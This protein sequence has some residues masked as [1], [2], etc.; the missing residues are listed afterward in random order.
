M[1]RSLI[2][3]LIVAIS[4]AMLVAPAVAD[5]GDS[6]ADLVYTPVTPCRI[7]DTRAVAGGRLIPGAQRDFLVSGTQSFDTQGGTTGGCGIPDNATAAMLNFVAVTPSGPGDLRAWPYGQPVPLASIV[8]YA[9]VAGLNLANGAVVA[10]CNSAT[11]TCTFDV[12]VQADASAT[13]LVVDVIGFLQTTA[14][15]RGFI[16]TGNTFL[17]VNAGNASGTDNTA[18]GSR[19]LGSNTGSNNTAVGAAALAANMT[20]ALN[21]AI[22]VSALETNTTGNFNTATGFSALE[23][24]STGS[25]NTATGAYA[26]DV[27]TTGVGNTATGANALQSNNGSNNTATGVS[28]LHSNTTGFQN[29]AMGVNA[30]LNNITGENNT[31]TGT[32]ALQQ[33]NAGENTATG[34]A[35]LGNNTTGVRNTAAG[36]LALTNNTTGG[37]NAAFGRSALQSNITGNLNTAVGISALFNNTT[38]SGNTAV[39][40]GADV[41][42]GGLV[43]ATAIGN[44][45]VVNASNKIRLGNA[46][47]TVIEGQVGFTS[48]SDVTK[49]ENFR[50]VDG[51][52]V[53]RK[54]LAF[55]LSS[56]NF[57]GQDA[58]HFRHYGPSA[59][60]FFAA[61]G[62]DGMGMI[63]TPT[64]ITSTDLDGVLMIAVQAL[65]RR[66][67]EIAA[68]RVRLEVLERELLTRR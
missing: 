35:A 41:S 46:A 39:G 59:Q 5:L 28:A 48:S 8:N 22:G 49:K 67:E 54:L 1:L 24:N 6:A 47:V 42:V 53:L 61:F 55:T 60:D 21:T 50:P 63:G 64:T 40:D 34:V 2:S 33:N 44:G 38:G 27:N 62:H 51:D 14:P 31:A 20:G 16:G 3:G 65:A 29:T 25:N 12:S 18:V 15:R 4:G 52:E 30:L 45:A 19:A 43:N 9:A 32:G 17:G 57:I 23:S 11:T 13:D 36:V 66:I 56:W 58:S 7:V 26:L 68:L 10:L 37:N